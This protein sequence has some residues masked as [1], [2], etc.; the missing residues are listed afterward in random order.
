MRPVSQ[1]LGCEDELEGILEILERGTG[2]EKQRSVFGKHGSLE[3]VA[4]Y[5]VAAT[6]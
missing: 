2:A 4:R 6:A 5:L 3:A 1:D